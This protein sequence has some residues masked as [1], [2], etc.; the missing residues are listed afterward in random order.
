MLCDV[1]LQ[2]YSILLEGGDHSNNTW[3]H[4][5]LKGIHG[6]G[7]ESQDWSVVAEWL[8]RRTLNQR[9]VGSNNMPWV[10]TICL[11]KLVTMCATVDQI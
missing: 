9:A 2:Q 8:G 4:A 6:V 1:C 7:P 3:V 5:L 10:G 11:R